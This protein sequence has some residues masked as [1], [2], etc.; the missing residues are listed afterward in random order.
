[1]L[2][3]VMR[4]SS[5]LPANVVTANFCEIK[6]A[7]NLFLLLLQAPLIKVKAQFLLWQRFCQNHSDVV[8]WKRA[9]KLCHPDIFPAIKIL[10]CI[11]AA[12]PVSSATAERSFSMLRLMK[13]NLRTTMDHARFDDLCL[14]YIHNGISISTGA[15]I[16]KFAATSR[17]IKL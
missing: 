1:M 9:F 5:L 8:V 13:S 14:M 7:V 16:K 3:A 10:L 11:L 6:S 2:K 17:K 12:L 15:I 4:L